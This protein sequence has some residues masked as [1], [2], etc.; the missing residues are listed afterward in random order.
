MVS[1][2]ISLR[3][4]AAADSVAPNKLVQ[5]VSMKSHRQVLSVPDISVPYLPDMQ[6]CMNSADC[7][8][9][10]CAHIHIVTCQV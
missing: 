3:M 2:L 5:I 1:T 7:I 4:M 9:A 8:A 6:K 10:M